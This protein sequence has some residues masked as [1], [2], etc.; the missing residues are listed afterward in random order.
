MSYFN[1]D[2]PDM[3]DNLIALRCE[4]REFLDRELPSVEDTVDGFSPAFS[5]KCGEAGFIGMTWPREYGGQGRSYLERYVVS[6]EL[7]AAK[8]PVRAHWVADRQSGPM[9]LNYGNEALCKKLFTGK[10]YEASAISA[11]A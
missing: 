11:L 4:I 5:R 6:E 8:A 3:P 9:L 10:S 2:I 7:L 1:F